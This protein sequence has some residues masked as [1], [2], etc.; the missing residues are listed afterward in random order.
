VWSNDDN[1]GGNNEGLIAPSVYHSK[2]V[3]SIRHS[4]NT[5]QAGTAS[6]SFPTESLIQDYQTYDV[7][8]VGPRAV[9][10]HGQ[11][12]NKQSSAERY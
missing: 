11:H 9:S 1:A 6:R 12:V 2:Y 3:P 5:W 8:Q 7:S 4:P 10:K